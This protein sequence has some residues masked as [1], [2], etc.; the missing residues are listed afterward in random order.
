M[1]KL[2]NLLVVRK[3]LLLRTAHHELLLLSRGLT[4]WGHIGWR[5]HVRSGSTT[6]HI[7]LNLLLKLG[8]CREILLLL[9]LS[10]DHISKIIGGIV[11]TDR[12]LLL[13]ILPTLRTILQR[14]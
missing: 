14:L 7:I 2:Y 6:G 8:Q 3:V 9:L 5:E 4:Q 10:L 1:S 13:L 11:R 12:L